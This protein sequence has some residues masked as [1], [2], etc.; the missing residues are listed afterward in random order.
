LGA[1]SPPEPVVISKGV[2]ESCRRRASPLSVRRY[3]ALVLIAN[4]SASI[5][6]LLWR[7]NVVKRGA[8]LVGNGGGDKTAAAIT[9]FHRG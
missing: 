7:Q 3:R 2:D 4:V 6:V 1:P 8:Q 9:Q 5:S